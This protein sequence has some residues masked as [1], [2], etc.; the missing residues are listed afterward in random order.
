MSEFGHI[1]RSFAGFHIDS[2][3]AG[4]FLITVEGKTYRFEDSDRFGP[5]KLRADGEIA[6]NP[7]WPER[8]L[9]WR[10]HRLWCEQGRRTESD[11]I[12]CIWEGSARPA[13]TVYRTVGRTK[14]VILDGEDGGPAV[15]EHSPAGKAALAAAL[16]TTPVAPNLAQGGET[17]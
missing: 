11:G 17:L 3:G 13:P 4:P 16:P 14:F 2:W 15:S 7:W 6:A 5:S 8:S 10:A 9:F 12:T 1:A